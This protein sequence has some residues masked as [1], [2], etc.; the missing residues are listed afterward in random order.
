L[1]F[2]FGRFSESLPVVFAED[3]YP[4]GHDLFRFSVTLGA[5]D[6]LGTHRDQAFGYRAFRALKLVKRHAVSS[7]NYYLKDIKQLSLNPFFG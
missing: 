5:F 7:T 3:E 2:S 4:S 6:G 1:D